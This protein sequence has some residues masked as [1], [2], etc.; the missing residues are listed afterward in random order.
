MLNTRID[1]LRADIQKR[2]D[3]KAAFVAKLLERM[4]SD[5]PEGVPPDGPD[6]M[7]GPGRGL[8]G[9]EGRH[10]G[11]RNEGPHGQGRGDGRGEGPHG[12]NP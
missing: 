1:S 11:P 12:P 3:G 10:G 2:Q 4:S 9:G 5:E 7:G 6:S 8:E